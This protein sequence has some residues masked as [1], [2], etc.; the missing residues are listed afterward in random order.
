MYSPSYQITLI[1]LLRREW[2]LRH[3]SVY[4]RATYIWSLYVVSLEG[5]KPVTIM[6]QIQVCFCDMGQF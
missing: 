6:L 2:K 1:I 5:L 3:K 4:Y